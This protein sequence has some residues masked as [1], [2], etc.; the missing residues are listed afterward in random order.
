MLRLP[1]FRVFYGPYILTDYEYLY[2]VFRKSPNS[3]KIS[4]I[5]ERKN[6][7]IR[8]ILLNNSRRKVCF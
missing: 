8:L 3:F 6:L 1:K 2:A 5:T 4:K 7:V